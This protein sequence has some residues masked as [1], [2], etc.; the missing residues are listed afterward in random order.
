LLLIPNIVSGFQHMGTV[1]FYYLL[2]AAGI[3]LS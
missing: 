2:I 3:G 1:T